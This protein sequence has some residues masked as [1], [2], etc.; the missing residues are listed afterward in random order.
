MKHRVGLLLLVLIVLLAAAGDL[1]AAPAGSLPTYQP[2]PG[3]G[4]EFRGP[5]FY[6]SFWKILACWLVFLAFVGTADWIS[7]DVQE[8][9]LKWTYLQ[10]NP[11]VV[12]SFFAGLVLLWLIPV[13]WVGFIFLLIAYVAPL[14]TYVLIRNSQVPNNQRVFTREHLRYVAAGWLS[15]VGVKIEA[16]APDV[17]AKGPP[18]TVHA[19]GGADEREDSARLLAARQSP[20]LRDARKIIADG[21]ALRAD[22]ILL[23]YTQQGVAVRYQIDGV[24]HPREGEERDTADPAL[25]ALK[26]L[27]GLKPADRQSRQEGTFAAEYE[28]IRFDATLAAQGTKTGERV[29]L[30]FVDPKVRFT[31]LEELGMRPKMQEQL[32]ELL[33]QERGIVVLSGVPGGGLRNTV[34]VTLHAMDRLTRE[35]VA[36]EDAA[37]RH[38]EIE[39]VPVTT[40]D[41]SAGQSP[42]DT[43]ARL[44][45]TDPNVLVIRDLV[46]GETLEMLCDEIAAEGRMLLTTTRA[47]EAAEAVLRILALGGSPKKYAK[48]A[49]GALNQRLIRKLCADC[50]EAYSPPQQVLQQLGIPPGRVQAF[51]R[52]PQQPE[53][54]CET[55]GGIGYVGRTALFELLVVG[56]KTRATLAASPKLETVRKA[57]RAD[58][59]RTLQEEGILLVA[60]GQ[61]SLPELMRVLKG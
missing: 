45:R 31:T 34:D 11:I 10:W 59:M 15:R 18:V 2:N 23:D 48:V 12:G 35:F 14:T 52:P 27:C 8:V 53:E 50:K 9:R 40:Y 19:R 20:G 61:T 32:K 4:A 60:K 54:V 49:A 37:Q 29:L 58:G 5:G 55:C 33:G 24:W 44:F 36:V 41:R 1:M 25:E 57:A 42:K 3:A 21:L 38:E 28:G 46:D 17:H 56:E 6:F 39:N 26:I 51:Y 22:S 30:Q 13:F 47:K 7:R 16:E 43:L